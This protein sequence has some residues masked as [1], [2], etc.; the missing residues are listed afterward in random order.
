MNPDRTQ[1]GII[2]IAHVELVSPI[3][4]PSNGV[5]KITESLFEKP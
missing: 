3:V 1:G 2:S 5:Y 4:F